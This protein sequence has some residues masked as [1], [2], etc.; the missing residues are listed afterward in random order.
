MHHHWT[1]LLSLAFTVGTVRE[2]DPVG[3]SGRPEARW[4]NQEDQTRWD[5]E[6]ERP[7]GA[8]K[9]RPDGAERNQVGNRETKRPGGTVRRRRNETVG[10]TARG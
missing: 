6:G 2:R 3:H 10:G 1:L 4:D 7:D 8:V 9:E 5:S